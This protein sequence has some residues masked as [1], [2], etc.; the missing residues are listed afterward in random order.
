MAQ[1]ICESLFYLECFE[2]AS[3]RAPVIICDGV[4][5]YGDDYA[6]L[7][8]DAACQMRKIITKETRKERHIIMSMLRHNVSPP[9]F[10]SQPV[11]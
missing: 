9:A 10:P 7:E 11:C 6:E 2:K 4:P 8:R 3:S 1:S 5:I